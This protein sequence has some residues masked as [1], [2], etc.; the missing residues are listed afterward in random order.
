MKLIYMQTGNQYYK[1][2]SKHREE[3][4]EIKKKRREMCAHKL[5]LNEIL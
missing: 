2:K 1:G 4:E 5:K 3:K